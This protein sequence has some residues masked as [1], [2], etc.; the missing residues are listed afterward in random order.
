[1]IIIKEE[2]IIELCADFDNPCNEWKKCS[3]VLIGEKLRRCMHV[4]CIKDGDGE[5][6]IVVI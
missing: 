5:M 1:M 6:M 2:L 4:T 3:I